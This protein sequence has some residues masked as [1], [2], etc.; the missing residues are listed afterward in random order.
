MLVPNIEQ[1]DEKS[2]LRI[3]KSDGKSFDSSSTLADVCGSCIYPASITPDVLLEFHVRGDYI[4]KT[5]KCE[6]GKVL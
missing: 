6:R 1:K 2:T 5:V 3:S 4:S